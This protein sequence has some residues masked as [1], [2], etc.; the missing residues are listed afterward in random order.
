[1][2]RVSVCL[3]NLN[4]RP[5]LPERL[6]SIFDQ[7]FTDWELVVVD[8]HSQDGAW[9]YFVEQAKREPRMRI[10]QA[11]REGMY[12]NWNNC[13]RLSRGEFIYIATSD[14]TM[15]P[16]CLERM[17]EAL[18]RNQDCAIAHC[19]MLTIDKG[20]DPIQGAW[21]KA[22]ITRFFGDWMDRPHKRLAPHDGLLYCAERCV[23][24][25]ITQL[26][27]RRGLFDEIGLFRDDLGSEGDWEWEMRASL[28]VNT[29]HVPEKLATWRVHPEQAT[30]TGTRPATAA[31][32]AAVDRMIRQA[33][34]AAGTLNPAAT[35]GLD[36]RKMTFFARRNFVRTALKET[37]GPLERLG[38][39]LKYPD[40][41]AAGLAN[42]LKGREAPDDF[43]WARE[44]IRETTGNRELIRAL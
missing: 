31:W 10:S 16:Q 38:I 1:M 36:V 41:L 8:N 22:F 25:S 3:P 15:M 14:D 39:L 23:Y 2:P 13:V 12:P 7:T 6:Q 30:K 21:E 24:T 28:L 20:G 33:V 18:D 27:I 43:A 40:V 42:R 9:E 19:Q 35:A 17:V 11:P 5:F 37:Q 44:L 32:H 29:V 26:L 4:T 34:E